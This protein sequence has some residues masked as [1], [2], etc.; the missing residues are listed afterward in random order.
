MK[1]AA[2]ATRLLQLGTLISATAF[3]GAT[4]I[5]IYARFFMDSAPSWTEEAARIFFIYTMSFAAGLALKDD[6]F[7]SLDL[8]YNRLSSDTRRRLEVGLYVLTILL[9]GIVG[10]YSIS[11]IKLG[12]PEKSPSMGI[13]MALSFISIFVMALG[14]VV[15]SLVRL[16][17]KNS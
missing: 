3:I 4:L 12:I 14:V 6:Y 2:F 11:F 8:L 13:P 7:V 10:W 5:Q 16:A 9:F 17:K 1:L 15:F